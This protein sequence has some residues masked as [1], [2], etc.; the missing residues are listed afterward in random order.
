MDAKPAPQA[1]A[2]AGPLLF[3]PFVLRE[4]TLNV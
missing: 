2:Q 4:L 1:D 3:S